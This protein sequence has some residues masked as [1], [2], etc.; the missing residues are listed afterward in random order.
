MKNHELSEVFNDFEREVVLTQKGTADL[1]KLSASPRLLLKLFSNPRTRTLLSF[2]ISKY[3]QSSN[4]NEIKIAKNIVSQRE[5]MERISL[6][7]GLFK[8]TENGIP[9]IIGKNII[10]SDSGVNPV[11]AAL[12]TLKIISSEAR[13]HPAIIAQI[14]KLIRN[15]IR[16]YCKP[17]ISWSGKDF[18][19]IINFYDPE[20][21]FEL[22]LDLKKNN[23]LKLV[24]VELPRVGIKDNAKYAYFF[25]SQTADF[26]IDVCKGLKDRETLFLLQEDLIPH[27]KVRLGG[28]GFAIEDYEPLYELKTK[29]KN[30]LRYKLPSRFPSIELEYRND[31]KYVK[32]FFHEYF[33]L[34]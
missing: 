24:F 31:E 13:S 9:K 34:E 10:L 16:D 18:L 30:S 6:D 25:E 33:E 7:S 12:E 22:L 17:D 27:N 14:P 21:K 2:M 11:A 4:P 8:V 29:L 19:Q 23:K 28:Y 32:N 1:E 26:F 15:K 20:T 5:I 3:A